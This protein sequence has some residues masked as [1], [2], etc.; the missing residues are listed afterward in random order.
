[1]KKLLIVEDEL[2]LCNVIKDYFSVRD[3]NI[4]IANNIDRIL[5]IRKYL[6]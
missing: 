2:N 6:Y 4:T 3:F 1:M 5:D